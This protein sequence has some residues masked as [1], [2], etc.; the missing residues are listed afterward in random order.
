MDW[1]QL[2]DGPGAEEQLFSWKDWDQNDT[3]TFQFYDCVL[4]VPVGDLS[5]GSKVDCIV[6]SFEHAYIQLEDKEGKNVHVFGLHLSVGEEYYSN[7]SAKA[8][9]FQPAVRGK[10]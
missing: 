7:N 5:V 3:A 10:P 9:S 1:K 4:K 8:R 6:V 2:L